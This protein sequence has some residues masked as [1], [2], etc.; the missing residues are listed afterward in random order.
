MQSIRLKENER[1]R[2]DAEGLSGV[3]VKPKLVFNLDNLR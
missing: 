2:D 3:E 1:Q